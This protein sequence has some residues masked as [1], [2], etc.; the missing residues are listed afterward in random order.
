M[1]AC[2]CVASSSS[3]VALFATALGGCA[4]Q[5]QGGEV[6]SDSDSIQPYHLAAVPRIQI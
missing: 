2:A 1:A 3:L 6:A 5:P 4:A